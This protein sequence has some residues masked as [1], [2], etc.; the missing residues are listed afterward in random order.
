MNTVKHHKWAITDEKQE[1]LV[2]LLDYA[3]EKD[4]LEEDP[5]LDLLLEHARA[6]PLAEDEFDR[7]TELA[8]WRITLDPLTIRQ[9]GA[10]LG[11]SWTTVRHHVTN[12]KRLGS[13]KP[14]HDR[15]VTLDQLRAFQRRREVDK[16]SPD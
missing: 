7:L 1:A 2:R 9:A 10:W 16:Y 5:L 15:L 6:N 8:Q 4:H 3:R 14:G 13:V 11:L 12:T